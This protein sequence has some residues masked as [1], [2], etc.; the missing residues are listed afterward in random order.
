MILL[1]Q[2]KTFVALANR[3]RLSRLCFYIVYDL[4]RHLSNRDIDASLNQ[5]SHNSLKCDIRYFGIYV[6][7]THNQYVNNT[8]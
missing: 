1:L 3:F 2:L 5:M 8:L 4:I 7:R 6:L